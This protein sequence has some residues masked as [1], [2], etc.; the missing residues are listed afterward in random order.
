MYERCIIIIK[1]YI[2]EK[3]LVNNFAYYNCSY[4]KGFAIVTLPEVYSVLTRFENSDSVVFVSTY[5]KFYMNYQKNTIYFSLDKF[6]ITTDPKY[7]KIDPYVHFDSGIKQCMDNCGFTKIE[8]LCK[9][10]RD[11][12]TYIQ[13]GYE[14][15]VN[16][17][18]LIRYITK[19]YQQNDTNYLNNLSNKKENLLEP[20]RLQSGFVMR[21]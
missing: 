4:A 1:I 16:I 18:N 3:D 6:E 20:T 8:E 10:L 2:M 17:R 12:D 15:G 13:P 11:C 7:Y 14:N 9:Y 21:I 19:F 5:D